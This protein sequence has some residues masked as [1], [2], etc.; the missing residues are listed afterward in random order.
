MK[1][2]RAG[3]DKILES[4]SSSLKIAR[5][6]DDRKAIYDTFVAD[7]E[8]L[9]TQVEQLSDR[10]EAFFLREHSLSLQK[11]RNFASLKNDKYVSEKIDER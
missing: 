8:A 2:Y 1:Q 6:E 3:L 9:R 4:F 11:V 7:L 10:Y 5:K